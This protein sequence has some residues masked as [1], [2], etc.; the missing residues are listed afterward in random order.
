MSTPFSCWHCFPIVLFWLLY[1]SFEPL[2]VS[3]FTDM[4]E[5]HHF[6]FKSGMKKW[7]LTRWYQQ[8][9]AF[10]KIWKKTRPA[11]RSSQP[12][13]DRAKSF[14]IESM[15]PCRHEITSSLWSSALHIYQLLPFKRFL[16]KGKK[17]KRLLM[18]LS[19]LVFGLGT[20]T[21]SLAI[22]HSQFPFSS[23]TGGGT[24]QTTREDK[25]RSNTF[26]QN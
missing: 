14:Q 21:V 4:T 2:N 5:T 3:S 22:K 16:W 24:W 19:A 18:I 1:L 23:S 17:K 12:A 9:L 26:Q 11:P 7:F 13:S 10:Y 25:M 20:N 6:L 8:C 15:R